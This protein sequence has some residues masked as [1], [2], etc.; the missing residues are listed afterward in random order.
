MPRAK[1]CSLC[2][3][4]LPASRQSTLPLRASCKECARSSHLLLLTITVLLMVLLGGMVAG[5]LSVTPRPLAF[6]GT[7]VNLDQALAAPPSEDQIIQTAS[8]AATTAVAGHDDVKTAAASEGAQRLCG[9][10]TKTG[11]PCRRKVR[12]GGYC[13]QHK[14]KLP[15]KANASAKLKTGGAP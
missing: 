8:D 11:R 15:P 3:A 9:A 13:Y 5:R 2:G 4:K 14:D 1:Y 10:P 6:L 7:A 12:D